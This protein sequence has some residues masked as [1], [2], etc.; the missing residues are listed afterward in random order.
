MQIFTLTTGHSLRLSVE[1]VRQVEDSCSLFYLTGDLVLRHLA[2]LQ[3]ECHVLKYG[4]VRVQSVVLENHRNIS[5]LR[6]NVVNESV[7]D[8]KLALADLLKTCDHTKC[9]GLT[10]AGRSNEDDKLL[11]SDFKV[12][13][14]YSYKAAGILL[15]N[16]SE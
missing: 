9:G 13:I 1:Q 7:S 11:I 10:A 15:I 14:G 16:T 3:A 6:S 2:E 4:H 5:V 12:Y 8:V